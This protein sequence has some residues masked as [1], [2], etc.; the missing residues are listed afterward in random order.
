M[1]LHLH[2]AERTDALADGL[3]DLLA[4]PLDDP[5]AREVVVVPARGVERW[6]TQRLS[7]RLGVG[8]ARG[9]GVCA[10][11]DFVTPHSLVAMLL[12]KDADDPWEPD[13][14]AWPLLEVIDDVPGRD[15]LRGAQPAPRPRATRRA[16][17]RK[18]RRYSV[19]RRLAG[20]FASYAVQRPALVDRLARGAR[21]RRGRGRARPRPAL[22]GRAVAAAARPRGRRRRPTSGTP[23]PWSGCAPAA[24]TSTCRRGCRCSATPACR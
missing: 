7:H 18:A 2:V 16:A 12:G 10:G 6:L 9:D 14:L 19:A 3:A 17:E 15:R 11:V 1:A 5:F 13:R 8:R 22:A 4:T 24:T 21:H 20:L 23:R